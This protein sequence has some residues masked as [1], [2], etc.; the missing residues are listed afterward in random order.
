MLRPLRLFVLALAALVLILPSTASAQEPMWYSLPYIVGSDPPKVGDELSGENG[1]LYCLPV[2]FSQVYQWYH[3]TA[4]TNY[5]NCVPVGPVQESKYYTVQATDVGWSLVVQV[6]ATNHDCNAPNT[7]CRDVTKWKNSLPTAP[8]LGTTTSPAPGGGTTPPPTPAP[9]PSLEV[10][11][12][13]L[14]PTTPGVFYSQAFDA[15]GGEKPYT[16][17]LTSGLLPNGLTLSND[18]VLSGI[19]NSGTGLFTFTIS[20]TD[21]NGIKTSRTLNLVVAAPMIVATPLALP[22]GL[23]GSAYALTLGATGGIAPYSYSLLD[24]ALPAGFSLTMGGQL[25][26]TPV[27]AGTTLFTVQ[28]LDSR[29]STGT[30]TYRLVVEAQEPPVVKKPPV[31][32]KKP[33]KKK[34]KKR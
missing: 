10:S 25:S 14:F 23:V 5:S 20:V 17:S 6:L 12:G 13:A 22:T 16:Y 8:V 26:G 28:M 2:C 4:N 33:V 21:K 29:G 18:G 32:K 3:C 30:Q 27:L 19:A 34:P 1:G 7:E 9:A 31:T 15:K 24:G 11:P